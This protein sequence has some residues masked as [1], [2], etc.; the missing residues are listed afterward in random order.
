VTSGEIKVGNCPACGYYPVSVE[1][2]YCVK[3]G[4][5]IS[6]STKSA[7]I[8]GVE[9][10]RERAAR[11]AEERRK[12][13]EESRKRNA[14]IA[15]GKRRKT[16]EFEKRLLKCNK[17]GRSF[18]ANS[19]HYHIDDS[20]KKAWLLSDYPNSPAVWQI[21]EPSGGLAFESHKEYQEKLKTL[22]IGEYCNVCNEYFL[23]DEAAHK[24]ILHRPSSDSPYRSY[25][26]GMGL[27][28]R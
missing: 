22:G 24:R 28:G 14:E 4:H 6:A 7:M 10:N 8:R 11:E 25:G 2:A 19:G 16:E 23:G 12:K 20:P 3:C 17:C 5:P 9:E 21:L 18:P 15:A 27:G 1:A 13:D 26:P